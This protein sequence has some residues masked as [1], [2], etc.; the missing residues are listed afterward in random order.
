MKVLCLVFPLLM[1]VNVSCNSSEEPTT[2]I[3]VGS[4]TFTESVILGEIVAQLARQAE[5]VEV[6]HLR[7]LGGTRVLWSALLK[8]EIDIYPEYRGTIIQ[9][10]LA[11]EDIR[12]EETLKRTLAEKN[13][14]MSRPLG[15]NN[16][17]AIGMKEDVAE[18]LGINKISDL[19]NHPQLRFGFTNEFMDRRDGW[20]SLRRAYSLPQKNVR[21]LDHDLAYRGLESGAIQVTDLYS[22]DAEIRYYNLRTLKD[23]LNHF[24][25]YNAVLLYRK[26]LTSRVPQALKAILQL[27]GSISE[28]EMIQMNAKV[29][30]EGNSESAVASEFLQK[31]LS[32]TTEVREETFITRLMRHTLDHLFL[33]AVSLTAAILISIPLGI[34]AHRN[35]KIGR[36]ILGIVGIIQTIPSLALLVFMIP[37]LGIGS[38]PAIVALFLYS[39]LPIVRNTYSGLKDIPLHIRESAEALGLSSFARLR[40]IELPLASRSILS[41]IKTSAVIN[42]GVATLGALIGAGGYG[43]PILTGIRLDD[44]GLILEGAIPAAILALLVQG[45]FDALELVLVPKGLRL[46][47]E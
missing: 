24:P 10:I 38:T 7:E 39:L 47:G 5:G 46:K 25:E 19:R 14:L 11:G 28:S 27:E 16:T 36:V 4:K 23:D 2:E 22:T 3:K 9:E 32:I 44:I 33:V 12:D 35:E 45:L 29:K 1:F 17:Y 8:G 37:L 6:N 26:D 41:G 42:V 13:I 30:I 15:F 20:P 40:L 31:N 18:R 34:W 21:G 43:Q